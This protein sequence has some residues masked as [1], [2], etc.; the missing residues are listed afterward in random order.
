MSMRKRLCLGT[1]HKGFNDILIKAILRR[2]CLRVVSAIFD[3][4]DH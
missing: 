2:I 4:P 3:S 1:C